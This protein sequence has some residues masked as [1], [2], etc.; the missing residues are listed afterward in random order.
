MQNRLFVVNNLNEVDSSFST[1][2]NKNFVDLLFYG[3]EKFDE[4]NN[5][6]ILICTVDNCCKF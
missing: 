4:E 5:C 1:L 3:N 6:S 2:N